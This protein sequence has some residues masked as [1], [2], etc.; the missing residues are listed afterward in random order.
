MLADKGEDRHVVSRHVP[1][2]AFIHLLVLGA[3]WREGA[4][5]GLQESKVLMHLLVMGAF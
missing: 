1:I 4:G 5:H 2:Y 3:F